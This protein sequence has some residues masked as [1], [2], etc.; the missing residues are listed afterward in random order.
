M[1]TAV[2]PVWRSPMM[3]SRW[4]RPT[5]TSESMALRPVSM[6]SCTDWRAMIPGAFT[7]MRLRNVSPVMGPCPSIGLPSA[8]TTRP[9]TP[10][11]TG[12][13]IIAPVRLTVSPSLMSR[14]LPNTT[15]PTLSFSRLSAMPF[16]PESNS[17]ISPACTLARPCT[18]AMP[19]P[20]ASTLPTSAVSELEANSEIFFSMTEDSSEAEG[21][22]ALAPIS[23]CAVARKWRA[24]A[25]RGAAR[26]RTANERVSDIVSGAD[27]RL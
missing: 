7:S 2:L 27:R 13:S 1:A 17:T 9:S 8:S 21:M 26:P 24:D 22:L 18:R 19:S 16:S 6:G 12:M 3:S 14:S 20:M 10:M 25:T 5:G 4:P 15:M 11:P 23:A